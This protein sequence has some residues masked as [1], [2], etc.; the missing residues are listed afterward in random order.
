[1]ISKSNVEP[2]AATVAYVRRLTVARAFHDAASRIGAGQLAPRQI[3]ELK[4]WQGDLDRLQSGLAKNIEQ[5]L[6]QSATAQSSNT[7]STS[8]EFTSKIN[9]VRACGRQLAGEYYELAI[10][11]A[12]IETQT[13][14]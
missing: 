11:T 4:I 13:S 10:G 14:K 9:S 12:R 3:A 1:M 2:D 6:S 7:T 5:Y 8:K